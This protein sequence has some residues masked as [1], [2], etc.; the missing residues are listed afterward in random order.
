MTHLEKQERNR[1]LH[2]LGAVG[3][4]LVVKQE[5][6]G[7]TDAEITH[8]EGVHW[9]RARGQQGRYKQDLRG[10]VRGGA[11]IRAGTL[12]SARQ[13]Q[14]QGP[15]PR[16]PSHLLTQPPLPRHSPSW[17]LPQ[18]PSTCVAFISC[19]SRLSGSAQLVFGT[20]R[21]AVRG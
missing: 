3:V 6:C 18:L 2:I 15:L 13:S 21:F 4:T 8:C 19:L 20:G 5:R 11:R 7:Q 10:R 14:L 12:I 16:I 17:R 1:A 9:C